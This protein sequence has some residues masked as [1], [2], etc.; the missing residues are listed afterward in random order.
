MNAVEVIFFLQSCYWKKM[1]I[2]S[3]FFYFFTDGMRRSYNR[4]FHSFLHSFRK[5]RKKK[6]SS[7]EDDSRSEE[8]FSGFDSSFFT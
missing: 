1:F 2:V 4:D 8:K 7:Q 3:V 6:V 5:R